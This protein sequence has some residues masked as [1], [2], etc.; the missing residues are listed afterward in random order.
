ML[1]SP[2]SNAIYSPSLAVQGA[3]H[4][5]TRPLRC[6]S[7]VS[8]VPLVSLL[9]KR[10]CPAPGINKDWTD[11]SAVGICRD[12]KGILFFLH[13][14]PSPGLDL[15]L[16]QAQAFSLPVSFNRLVRD[17]FH[18][19]HPTRHSSEPQSSHHEYALWHHHG[20]WLQ[21]HWQRHEQLHGRHDGHGRLVPDFRESLDLDEN[22]NSKSK[23]NMS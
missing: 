7:T 11:P 21:P 4:L 14:L 16:S 17:L 1:F 9:R 10:P 6:V 15:L 3:I 2:P 22:S 5:A 18:P 23:S 12:L 20:C 13:L 19:L 8:G